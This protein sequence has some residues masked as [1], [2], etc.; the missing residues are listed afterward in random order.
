MAQSSELAGGEGF[1]F[2]GYAA[3][4]YMSALLSEDF[5]PGI[6][7]RV[8][9]GVAV[10]QR[11]FGEPLDDLIVDFED[12]HKHKARFSI[13]VKRSLTISSAK[14][15]SDFR[16]IIRDSWATFKKQNFRLGIDRYGAAVG[17]IAVRKLR[18]ISTLSEW[19]RESLT[20]EHFNTRFSETGN[21]G[22]A[23]KNVRNDIKALLEE[24][25]DSECSSSDL[26]KFLAHFIV[27][28][29]DFLREGST[30][31]PEAINTIKSCL[32]H[33]DSEK[34]PLVWSKF[35]EMARRSAG[36]SGQFDRRRLVSS[37][38]T[39]V[40]IDG[41]QSLRPDL[42]LLSRLANDFINQIPDDVGG[43][44]LERQHLL[45]ELQEKISNSRCVK[46]RGLPGSGKSV[47]VKRAVESY[48]KDGPVL[49]L[50][51]EHLEGS[52]WVSYANLHG[53]SNVPIDVL[54]TEISAAGTP[55][56]FIDSVDRIEKENQFVVLD[57]IQAIVK[58]NNHENWT[59]VMSFRDSGAEGLRNWLGDLLVQNKAKT[60]SVG[61]LDDEEAEYL[62][63][64]KPH[65]RTLLFGTSE[66]Q[67]I[68]RRPF[69]AK[70]L[71]QAYAYDPEE[72]SFCPQS[73]LD[74]I[75]N[76]WNRGG[77]NSVGQNAI[78][79][80]QV[81]LDL[82]R[83]HA[84]RLSQPI[85]LS[86]LKTVSFVEDFKSDGI[87]QHARQ[88]IS[89]RFAHDIFFE[90]AFFY[91]L[92][93]RGLRWVDEIRACGEPP[94][95][96][97]VV[98]L[99]SQWE[100]LHGNNWTEFLD[101]TESSDLRSQ[102][103]RSCLLAPLGSNG[104]KTEVDLFEKVVFAND[105][106][107]FRK[108]LVWFQAEKT[109]PNQLIIDGDCPPEL[110]QRF[111]DA[112]GWPSDIAAWQRLI[113][114]VLKRINNIPTYLYPEIVAIFEVW[115]NMFSGT[116]NKLSDL[117]I[118]RCNTWLESI[119][120]INPY[121][122]NDQY[123]KLWQ[124]V[125]E[126]KSF[127][128]SLVQLIFR[129]SRVNSSHSTSYLNGLVEAKSI[130]DSD[131]NN[132]S[133][134]APILAQ[135]VPELLVK[136]TLSYLQKELP[137]DLVSR[138]KKEDEESAKWRESVK[139]KPRS[140]R[141]HDERMA[142]AS[143]SLSLGHD[144]S[145]YDWERLSL[146]DSFQSLYPPSPLREP[147]H[148]LFQESPK[149]AI[150]LLTTLC[151]HATSAWI[152]LHKYD[153]K[154]RGTPVPLDLEFPWGAQRF[155]GTRREYLWTRSLFSPQIIG[156]GFMALEEWCFSEISQG[157]KVDCLIE[158][159]VSGNECFAILGTAV[160]LAL[161]TNTVSDVTFSL[162]TSQRIL[163]A[164]DNRASQ[165]HSSSINLMGFTSDSETTH[166]E[167]IQN[168]NKRAVRNRKLSFMI[169][170]FV[171]SEQEINKR[172]REAILKFPEN[173]PFE[174]EEHKENPAALQDFRE[175][176]I[177]YAEF[178]ERDNYRVVGDE[179]DSG[180][181]TLQ[182]ISPSAFTPENSEKAKEASAWLTQVNLWMWANKSFESNKVDERFTI[183]DAVNIAKGF[184][185]VDLFTYLEH[186]TDKEVKSNAQTAVA[187]TASIVLYFRDNVEPVN[188][189]WARNILKRV[190]SQY[191]SKDIANTTAAVYPS[192]PLIYVARG[193]SSDIIAGTEGNDSIESL[194][195]LVSYPLDVVSEAALIE[196]C[197]LW[198]KKP[199]LSWSA[200]ALALKLCQV[201][202]RFDEVSQRH[203]AS[204]HEVNDAVSHL[205]SVLDAYRNSSD[206]I[207]LPMPPPAWIK[208]DNESKHA[209]RAY[210][211]PNVL[212][213]PSERWVEPESYW[214]AD[215]AGTILSHIP[216][217][218]ILSSEFRGNY[219]KF[220]AEVLHW[221]IQKIQP[222]WLKSGRRNQSSAGY[223]EWTCALGS[224]LG[225]VG[226]LLS[227]D[228]FN[229]I[230]I[231]PVFNLDDE[232][233]WILLQP[234]TETYI[235]RYI[236]DAPV[237]PHNSFKIVE[238]C[239]DRFLQSSIF[240]A[241]SYNSGEISGFDEPRLVK[242]LLFVSIRH[243]DLAERFIN[244]DWSDVN[245]LLPII[246]KFVRSG[247][248]SV[249]VMSSFLTLCERA[250]E[251]YPAEMFADQVLAVMG[252]ATNKLIGWQGTYTNARIAELVQFFAHRESPIKL[253][254][255]QKLLRILDILV[256]M[257][258]RRSAGLQ[259][260][261]MFR[262]ITLRPDT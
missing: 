69:F 197:K 131:F 124:E 177:R 53:L 243:A 14:T 235:C 172:T 171:F 77:Y 74:L 193:I 10:Q 260:S 228:E 185:S 32:V 187:G 86:T 83:N 12:V 105:Y 237:I 163:S 198:G 56:L 45:H 104:F 100:F 59:I 252:D 261:P 174:Y 212:I 166:I 159:I 240:K 202:P 249:T 231:D 111:A 221:S 192:H 140:E 199:R 11:D 136:V 189:D 230:F 66:V 67:K 101:Q 76:W 138:L 112:L 152:Q 5:A 22:K 224:E 106:H 82:A 250:K 205:D 132:I 242:T 89:V 194:L 206:C 218:G 122:T 175:Q 93:E 210:Q 200:I 108:V 103:L 23:E 4:Y 227:F 38:A 147:F 118:L 168:A 16:E 182:H 91:V 31:S 176:A 236:Y 145:D 26:H 262:E 234:M 153:F 72:I 52:S 40:R 68:V 96:A 114:F 255:A 213:D 70:V 167:A 58:S 61:I 42:D 239:L 203:E 170:N 181:I 256:D 2:E 15:N 134:F 107:L 135:S 88:G 27:V 160:M 216:I 139:K 146:N 158:E 13:Q 120:K 245:Q 204:P 78:D 17:T 98:E 110:R 169:P 62:A 215:R 46:I 247:G 51:A 87:L 117:L 71:D 1:T 24:V 201:Q 127:K 43:I 164:D 229:E 121:D 30:S 99:V 161:E 190:L 73:E 84:V 49:F 37:I 151:N 162:V 141:T 92:S 195:Y 258:D 144:F 18:A 254:L 133:S 85:L 223:F 248:W 180:Q 7:D 21:A 25:N 208:V 222:P 48:I 173:L 64:C 209:R 226:G 102:W 55:I 75:E 137:D 196:A 214:R 47:L 251:Y 28:N 113:I 257:G 232:N 79:R 29:F 36:K 186:D 50:K 148:S 219:I 19:A 34:A 188:L 246:D 156:C 155:W 97:R 157:R 20:T 57:I 8:V 63:E 241:G 183:I 65:L 238:L 128:E 211:N 184:D 54:L 259:L 119:E 115:Q 41:A 9:V 125:T 109:N 179:K 150:K 154:E 165:E 178:T 253:E 126:L 90:W 44:T 233:C 129:Y 33:Q 39:L 3:A 142:L 149:D 130:S 143:P 123:K 244:G 217:E 94:A 95:A 225:K 60:L 207:E 80:Q 35:V 220:L 116:S 81:L 6:E 191:D